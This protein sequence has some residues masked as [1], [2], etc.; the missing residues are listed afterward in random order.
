MIAEPESDTYKNVGSPFY[1]ENERILFFKDGFVEP[2]AIH[3]EKKMGGLNEAV[4]KD[5]SGHTVGTSAWEFGTCK[6]L[7]LNND[8]VGWLHQSYLFQLH[9][10]CLSFRQRSDERNRSSICWKYI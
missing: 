7:C 6:S 8:R 3:L 9:S 10:V 2:D 4:S 5:D 1:Y